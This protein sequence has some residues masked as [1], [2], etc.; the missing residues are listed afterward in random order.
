MGR[1]YHLEVRSEMNCMIPVK[2]DASRAEGNG[3]VGVSA[4]MKNRRI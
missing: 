3:G 2:E 1:I 4:G